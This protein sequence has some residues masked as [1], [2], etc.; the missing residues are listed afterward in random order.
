MTDT[1]KMI[2]EGAVNQVH[3][4]SREAQKSGVV[5]Y[6]VHESTLRVDVFPGDM[7]PIAIAKDLVEKRAFDVQGF[8][9][10]EYLL[11]TFLLAFKDTGIRIYPS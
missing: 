11:P 3:Y 7:I 6:H 9:V 10:P 1:F 5:K 4:S 2:G 8:I